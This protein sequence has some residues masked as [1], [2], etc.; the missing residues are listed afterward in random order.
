MSVSRFR[1]PLYQIQDP[2]IF[3]A[4]GRIHISFPE[5]KHPFDVLR[6]DTLVQAVQSAD[7][8]VLEAVFYS[9]G[10]TIKWDGKSVEVSAPCVL[11]IEK[12]K[13]GYKVSVTD[14]TMNTQLKNIEVKV[15]KVSA[16]VF[17]PDG[18]DCGKS[19]TQVIE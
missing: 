17:L 1:R 11:L 6:N 15:G 4:P 16:A 3:P 12:E 9:A 13:D 18:K 8:K 10:E 19:V 5:K 2:R 14:P 7:R